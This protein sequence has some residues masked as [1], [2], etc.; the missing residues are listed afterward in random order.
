MELLDLIEATELIT[1][2]ISH[3]HTLELILDIWV[4][5]TYNAQHDFSYP[6]IINFQFEDYVFYF[7]IY[8][9]LPR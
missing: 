9:E 8:R 3:Y 6:D 2:C 5:S 4:L 1:T 7:F